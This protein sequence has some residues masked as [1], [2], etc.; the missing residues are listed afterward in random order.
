M[1]KVTAGIIEKN[2]RILLAKRKK[3]DPLRDK[4]EFPGGKIEGDET[5]EECLKRELKEELGIDTEIGELVVTSRY[6]Y[7]HIAIELLAY[8][9]THISGEITALD[10]EELAWVAPGELDAYDIPE[11][12]IPVVEELRRGQYEGGAS[13]S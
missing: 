2:G 13:A 3:D 4:W 11:A 1:V 9:V 5:P 12:D 6:E 8:R 7:D 10:H